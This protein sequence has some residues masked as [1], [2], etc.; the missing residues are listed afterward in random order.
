MRFVIPAANFI[1]D[2]LLTQIIP[3]VLLDTPHEVQGAYMVWEVQRITTEMAIYY[4]ESM[5]ASHPPMNHK[6]IRAWALTH[7]ES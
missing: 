5:E 2:S 7:Q 1:Q 3:Q 6:D 4:T